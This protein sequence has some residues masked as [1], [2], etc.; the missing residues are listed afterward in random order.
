M[1]KIIVIFSFIL[2]FNFHTNTYAKSFYSLPIS[3]SSNQWSIKID[4]ADQDTVNNPKLTKAKKGVFNVYSLDISNIGERNINNV[5]IEAYRNEPHSKT[6]YE[7]FTQ[8]GDI[9]IK[10]GSS[11]HHANF[12]ISVKAKVF[13]VYI[14]W[15]K[16]IKG[17]Q[18]RHFKE[19]F[20]FH[21]K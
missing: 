9:L 5:K 2:G 1:K 15:E 6:Y 8:E 17:K 20:V 11:Y 3:K 16:T 10:D 19:T 7:L 18:I 13:K 12:P 4:Q 21:Q 14:T